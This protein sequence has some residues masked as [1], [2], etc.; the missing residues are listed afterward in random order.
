MLYRPPSA[1]VESIS[2]IATIV[3]EADKN[4]VFFGD[5]NLPDIELERGIARGRAA[6]LLEAA[7]DA[8]ME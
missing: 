4:S 5:F 2:E 8:M 1:Q 7:Q 6:E 3:R